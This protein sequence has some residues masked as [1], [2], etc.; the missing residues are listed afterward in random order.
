MYPRRGVTDSHYGSIVPREKS[1]QRQ[2]LGHWTEFSRDTHRGYLNLH[3]V[4]TSTESVCS[5]G[6]MGVASGA[7]AAT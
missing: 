4:V 1:I 7:A 6:F 5:P 3:R 2:I